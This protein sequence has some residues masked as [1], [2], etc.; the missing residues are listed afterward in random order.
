MQTY[1]PEL[2]CIAN[3]F[4]PTGFPKLSYTFSMGQRIME[5]VTNR[6]LMEDKAL[7][8][9]YK[10]TIVGDINILTETRAANKLSG[11]I[12]MNVVK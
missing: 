5:P 8:V 9:I 12:D 11:D 7:N 10:G 4:R 6:S 1:R 2:P 3:Y